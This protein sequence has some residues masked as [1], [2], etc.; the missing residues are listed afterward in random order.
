LF[1]LVNQEE[2]IYLV[3]LV[4]R[5][6]LSMYK[7]LIHTVAASSSPLPALSATPHYEYLSKMPNRHPGLKH[8][9]LSA[10]FFF[11]PARPDSTLL[12]PTN[13]LRQPKT[14]V[15]MRRQAIAILA[16]GGVSV[17]LDASTED[18]ISGLLNHPSSAD[19][20]HC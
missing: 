4:Y 3:F 8:A 16:L 6:C 17:E 12:P 19:V 13:C 10:H 5:I 18:P 15:P 1:E 7:P 2:T 14:L 20:V 9:L 11:S